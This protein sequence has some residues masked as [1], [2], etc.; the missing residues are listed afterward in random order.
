M[1]RTRSAA[2]SWFNAWMRGGSPASDDLADDADADASDGASPRPGAARPDGAPPPRSPQ[3]SPPT[4][5]DRAPGAPPAGAQG[6]PA[7]LTA[8]QQA[9]IRALEALPDE[10]RATLFAPGGANPASQ[11]LQS[12][13][14]R[15][16]QRDQRRQASQQSQAARADLIRREREARSTDVYEAARL[17]DELESYE[18]QEQFV[19]AIGQ[20]YDRIAIDPIVGALPEAER[21]AL[22]ANLGDV[23]HYEF[24]RQ[25]A[26]R[27]LKALK[28][29]WQ[30]EERER[31]RRN[32][33]FRKEVVNATR[34]A[35]PPGDAGT[36]RRG[37]AG[38]NGQYAPAGTAPARALP[39]W[40]RP[41]DVGYEPEEEGGSPELL[42]GRGRGGPPATTNQ[43]MN[44]FLRGQ[45]LP[46]GA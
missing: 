42:V 45:P 25:V 31:L 2:S 17:R 20:A 34:A 28:A 4:E 37:D 12:E 27:G 15:R 23:D 30:K 19:G 10:E 14:D 7:P 39:G 44:A 38:R 41:G 6:A 43:Y 35:P 26:E 11:L 33:T 18:A 16:N 32:P 29:H 22:F 5:A 8:R 36:R 24:R 1:E 46:D 40:G 3:G 21:P 13:V 9:A